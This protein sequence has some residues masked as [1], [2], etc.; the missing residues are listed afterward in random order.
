MD[1]STRYG[2]LYSYFLEVAKEVLY[3]ILHDDMDVPETSKEMYKFF[4]EKNFKEKVSKCDYLSDKQKKFLFPDNGEI[5]FS[6]LDFTMYCHIYSLLN[7]RRE[8]GLVNYLKKLRN[9]LCHLPMASI[10]KD[11]SQAEFEKYWNKT[12]KDFD[13]YLHG[14]CDLLEKCQ[15][16][17]RDKKCE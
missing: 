16:N 13:Y 3:K 8:K 7:G 17:I 1:T 11:F 2:K 14:H 9:Y 4:N 10:R 15:K 6:K 12:T 5:D